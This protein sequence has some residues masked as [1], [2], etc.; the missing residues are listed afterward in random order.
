[1]GLKFPLDLDGSDI[2]RAIDPVLRGFLSWH[3][4]QVAEKVGRGKCL[5]CGEELNL[6]ICWI[7][8]AP[9]VLLREL[10]GHTRRCRPGPLPSG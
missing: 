6:P 4:S 7:R 2:D 5:I 1:M 9:E 8:K 10:Q 3:W